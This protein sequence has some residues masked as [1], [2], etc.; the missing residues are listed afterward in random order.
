MSDYPSRVL[1]SLYE[2]IRDHLQEMAPN[3]PVFENKE[4]LL[5]EQLV[6]GREHDVRLRITIMPGRDMI[7]VY[8][9]LPYR[10]EEAGRKEFANWLVNYTYDQYY[11]GGY[12]FNPD[13]GCIVFRI[14]LPIMENEEYKKVLCSKIDYVYQAV[15]NS[16]QLVKQQVERAEKLGATPEKAQEDVAAT[17]E[18]N[19]NHLE[20]FEQSI[21]GW[22]D[23]KNLCREYASVA[24]ISE[25]LSAGFCLHYQSL[26]FSVDSG[27]GLTT[28]LEALQTFL[29]EL[30]VRDVD[31]QNVKEIVLTA[32]EELG[33]TKLED[34]VSWIKDDS[35]VNSIVCFDIS[36]FIGN[37]KHND[38][39][40]FLSLLIE[41]EDDYM[42]C[43]RV[44][45][46]EHGMLQKI[47][48]ILNDVL[49]TRL[50]TVAPFSNEM[51]KNA[52]EKIL[53]DAGFS[54]TDE[55]WELFH[56]RLREE[57]SDGK[58]Y[59]LRTVS[60]I[61]REMIYLQ[62]VYCS[63][64]PIETNAEVPENEP[65]DARK[66]V[67]K[68]AMLPLAASYHKNEKDGFDELSQLVGMEEIS[69]RIK[70]IVHQLRMAKAADLERPCLHM[71]FVG[72][73]GTGK[74]TVARILGRI[75][76]E[77][78]IL[79]NGYFFEYTGRD[80]CGQYV[81]QTA[82]RTASI[83]RD[84]YG[85]VLFIDEAYS[86]YAGDK[87]DN[88]YG[89][90]ALTTLISEMENHRDDMVVIMAGYKDDME[91]LMEGNAGLRSRIPFILEFKN[92]TK[93]QLFDIFLHF[94]KE[95]FT[96]T[97]EFF[98]TAKAYFMNMED[99][100]L[101][102]KEFANARFARNLYERTW[103]KAAL[104]CSLGDLT[105]VQLT[106]EDFVSASNEK[107]FSE[108]LSQKRTIG[109]GTN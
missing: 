101:A 47:Y 71:R 80:L 104:R 5:C 103:S 73:P 107:E 96:Y 58:F 95:H 16:T 74:T 60:K 59:G 23:L 15:D 93:E 66:E 6:S 4:K 3:L 17:K 34:A 100:Y 46:L 11:E 31:V 18:E 94:V 88:D 38:L 99:S 98:E 85:S 57:K 9:L 61:V 28:A 63:K 43:F 54:V 55:A 48:S 106:K 37:S 49:Y 10:C 39:K 2:T 20:K 70:E 67:C 81:G 84:A 29:A 108:K 109:F 25:T 14:A 102:A 89:R 76:Q 69:A 77:N 45:Y 62:L 12:D 78:G 91:K 92:Y 52:A 40:N 32:S 50:I 35:N 30:K 24:P 90:E 27:Y 53:V 42:F 83:C 21:V 64:L 19:Q 8:S 1:E 22:D 87:S 41:Y 56:A 68:E 33:K 82:P 65:K 26:L 7:A 36:E 44:P 72:A 13:D 97:D 79:R 51:L 86:L 105:N 75:F